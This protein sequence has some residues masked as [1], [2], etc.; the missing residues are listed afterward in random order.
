MW[1]YLQF[2]LWRSH[3][4]GLTVYILW[5]YFSSWVS[6]FVVWLKIHNS[7]AHLKLS[8]SYETQWNLL[9]WKYKI[10]KFYFG[11]NTKSTNLQIHELVIFNQTTKIDT[12]EEKY[13]HN[14]YTDQLR[15]GTNSYFEFHNYR[16]VQISVIL[17]N[18]KIKKKIIWNYFM[19]TYI[20]N[21]H[22][23]M[24]NLFLCFTTI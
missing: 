20:S 11:T 4:T 7:T 17:L 6:I 1:P 21:F 15:I 8:R 9:C 13:F 23:N 22:Q 3:K 2:S 14:I 19:S 5:K 16:S 10:H 12:H 24:L 18:L